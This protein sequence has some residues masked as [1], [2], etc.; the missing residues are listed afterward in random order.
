MENIRHQSGPFNDG[1]MVLRWIARIGSIASIGLLMAFLFGGN[2]TLPKFNKEAVGLVFFPLGVICGMLL[3]WRNEL[4]GGIVTVAS[5]L[6]FYGWHFLH[7]GGLPGGPYFV[8]FAFPGLLFG[9]VAGIRR[10]AK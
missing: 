7:A 1:L 5:L 4:L 3:G 9:L 2:E 6:A 8:I 10:I